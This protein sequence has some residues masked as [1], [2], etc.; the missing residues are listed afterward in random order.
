MKSY[1][2]IFLLSLFSFTFLCCTNKSLKGNR[3]IDVYR[4]YNEMVYDYFEEH[5]D[6]L[7]SGLSFINKETHCYSNGDTTVCL[8]FLVKCPFLSQKQCCLFL[9]EKEI[10]DVDV[11]LDSCLTLREEDDFYKEM[12]LSSGALLY[13]DMTD[14]SIGFWSEQVQYLDLQI[15]PKRLKEI[16]VKAKIG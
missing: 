2:S 11:F 1:R 6:T 14:N 8:L 15:T 4:V 13:Y 9:N 12:R 3:D 16:F 7:L 5:E 10:S